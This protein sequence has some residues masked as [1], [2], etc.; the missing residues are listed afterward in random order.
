MVV[1]APEPPKQQEVIEAQ[2]AESKESQK[3]DAEAS[4]DATETKD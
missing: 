2:V 4:D 1:K 3:E